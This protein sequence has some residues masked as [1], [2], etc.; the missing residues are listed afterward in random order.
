MT[1]KYARLARA[2]KLS[3]DIQKRIGATDGLVIIETRN[4]D[5]REE[6]IPITAGG[7]IREYLLKLGNFK[8]V[9]LSSE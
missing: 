8:D 2:N 4:P 6:F 3:A 5:L 9:E 1:L 7:G